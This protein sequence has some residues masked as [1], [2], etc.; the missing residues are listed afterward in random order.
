MHKRK[1]GFFVDIG[2]N[3]GITLSNSLAL[4]KD[5]GWNGLVIE[6]LP[7]HYESL[8]KLRNCTI[9]NV[10]VS[11][12][13]GFTKFNIVKNYEPFASAKGFETDMFSGIAHSWGWQKMVDDNTF[14]HR[15]KQ[16]DIHCLKTQYV[17]D[18]FEITHIDY[19]SIDAEGAEL[20]ILQG[21]D[22]DR[23]NI[24]VITV[25]YTDDA[26]WSFLSSRGYV[27]VLLTHDILAVKS[28]YIEEITAN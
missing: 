12:V 10:C 18:Q 13:T 23:M 3:D 20:M 22:W 6:P 28:Y 24:R 15:W 16:I 26:I 9:L 11:N 21:I 4:E 17:F 5:Y 2:A 25:D 14:T 19:L 1:S 27:L 7:K 8:M